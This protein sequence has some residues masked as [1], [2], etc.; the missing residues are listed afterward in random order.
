MNLSWAIYEIIL[1]FKTLSYVWYIQDFCE[2]THFVSELFGPGLKHS[3]RVSDPYGLF[4]F[5]K[6][7]THDF[8]K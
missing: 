8:L 6:T 2:R 5:P 3:L 1:Q 7:N 4:I